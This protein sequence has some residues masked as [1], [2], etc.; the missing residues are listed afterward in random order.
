MTVLCDRADVRVN[1]IIYVSCLAP[2]LG[3]RYHSIN[4]RFHHE[5]NDEIGFVT[6]YL[7]EELRNVR[8]KNIYSIIL[9][10]K[11]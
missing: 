9:G 11:I 8:M 5:T 1:E 7:K 6:E 2:G 10:I 4:S 3:H